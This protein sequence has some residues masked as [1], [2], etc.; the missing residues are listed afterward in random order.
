MVIDNDHVIVIHDDGR[1]PNDGHRA[2]SNRV[3]DTIRHFIELEYFAAVSCPGGLPL[4][5]NAGN[6]ETN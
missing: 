2:G 5:L 4:R 6:P 3:V 1:I